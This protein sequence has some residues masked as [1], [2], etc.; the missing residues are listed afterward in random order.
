MDD[1]TL[2]AKCQAMSAASDLYKAKDYVKAYETAKETIANDVVPE[3]FNLS[4][5]WIIYR[6]LKQMVGNISTENIEVCSKFFF[7]HLEQPSL[8]RSLF[9]VQMI[10]LSK[11]NT[12]FDFLAFCIRY[13]ICNLRS[14]DFIGNEIKT[15]SQVI[16]YDSLAEKLATR[17]YNIMKSTK[18]PHYASLLMPFFEEVKQ[19]C[20]KNKFID[21]YI[22]L[23]HYWKGEAEAARKVFIHILKTDPQWYIWKNMMYVS[24]DAEEKIAFCCKAATLV[25]DERFKGNLHLQLSE[26][27]VDNDPP[28]AAMEINKLFETYKSN[29]WRICGDAYILQNKLSG[30]AA[31]S[32]ATA[33]YCTYA[34][35]A[36]E[37]VYGRLEPVEMTYLKEITV[38]G[39]RKAN[40]YSS[41]PKVSLNVSVSRLGKG[42]K[43]GDVFMVRFN[44]VN[45]RPIVLTIDFARHASTPIR[46]RNDE[47]TEISG[48]VTLPRYGDYAFI[49]YKYYVPAK[50]RYEHN[51]CEGQEIRALACKTEYGKWRITK[52]LE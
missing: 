17:I 19:K 2:R 14:E 40:L 45:H 32:D 31:A 28:H 50:L 51:L 41:S 38:R 10:E 47:E 12:R 35:K 21:M 48:M 5:A 22:G 39:T 43:V 1:D 25:S 15:D 36:E 4:C 49:D 9:L 7:S 23:L 46:K 26:L 20:S 44:M 13:N 33:F 42:A 3:T 11:N 16:R 34:Q 6:Y 24:Q 52:I 37:I 8:V 27:L 18:S 29:N 30:V